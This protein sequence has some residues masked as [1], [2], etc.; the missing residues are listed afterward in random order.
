VVTLTP[1]HTINRFMRWFKDVLQKNIYTVVQCWKAEGLLN[2]KELMLYLL[3]M[4]SMLTATLCVWGK[5]I[6]TNKEKISKLVDELWQVS[7]L[8]IK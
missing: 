6:K 7:R 2:I 4:V 3:K 8:R 5:S 1:D